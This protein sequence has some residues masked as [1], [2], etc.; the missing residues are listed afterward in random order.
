MPGVQRSVT[1]PLAPITHR[2]VSLAFLRRFAG[3]L[4]EAVGE[5]GYETL[6]T[7]EVVHGRR[8]VGADGAPPGWTIR[9][10]TADATS[11]GNLCDHL[12]VRGIFSFLLK[13]LKVYLKFTPFL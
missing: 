5:E 7:A 3:L 2:A 6:T 9:G 8:G 12:A 4:K 10:M 13:I 1:V 11:S